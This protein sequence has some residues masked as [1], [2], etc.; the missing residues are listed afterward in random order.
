MNI[1]TELNTLLNG[2]GIPVETG[3]FSEKAPAEYIVITPLVDT[4]PIHA[5]N[6]PQ[7]ETQ[8]ARLSLF[9]KNN[10]IKRK[11][12]ITKEL[13]SADFTITERKYIGYEADS[14]YHHYAIDVAITHEF[15]EV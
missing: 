4:F 2:I 7:N 9:S 3:I 15:K 10:Y 1:L 8:E 5:D 6:Q 12:E 14:N 13:L 11:N